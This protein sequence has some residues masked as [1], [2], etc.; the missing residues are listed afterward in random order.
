MPFVR[1]RELADSEPVAGYTLRFVHGET[2]SVA[3]WEI[4]PGAVMPSHAHPNE[5]VS[6]M[7]EGEFEL[8]VDGDARTM[9]VGDAVVI[10]SGA[11][12]SGTALTRCRIYDAFHP[13]R[14]D[15]K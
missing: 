2:M 8:T 9:R 12:H 7:I 10:P 3:F 11:A 1:I 15:F 6:I 4:E 14:E 5:Q 13:R